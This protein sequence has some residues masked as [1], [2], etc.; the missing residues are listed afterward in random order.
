MSLAIP[1]QNLF[2]FH[3]AGEAN[4]SLNRIVFNIVSDKLNKVPMNFYFETV[5]ENVNC[6]VTRL[7][8]MKEG[9]HKYNIWVE[10]LEEVV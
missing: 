3:T 8:H 5:L 4:R 1:M 10:K 7:F 9:R 2:A 6:A